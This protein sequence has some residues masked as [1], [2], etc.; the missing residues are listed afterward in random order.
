MSLVKVTMT[1]Y[2]LALVAMGVQSFFFPLEGSKASP[3]SLI[4]AGGMGLVVLAMVWLSYKHP[5]PAYIVTVVLAVLT[6]L[7]FAPK[8][9]SDLYPALVAVV[10]SLVTIVVLGS[11]HMKAMADK[12]NAAA[13]QS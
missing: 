1:I 10:L 12:K 3:I 5:R 6:V 8:A 13:D 2:G 4:A 9:F 11:G 7:R